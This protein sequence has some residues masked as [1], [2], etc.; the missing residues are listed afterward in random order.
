MQVRLERAYQGKE[1]YRG[2][3]KKPTVLMTSSRCI[4]EQINRRCD[5]SHDHVHLVGGGAAAAQVYPDA[6]CQSIL[7]G[8]AERQKIDASRQV[9]S[10]KMS[11]DH[12]R[13][14]IGS[15]FCT[16][17]GTVKDLAKLTKPIGNWPDN[18]AEPAHQEDGGLDQYGSRPRTA[19]Q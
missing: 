1:G 14:F 5:G 8:I 16:D 12:L 17:V 7:R 4:A 13:S 11:Q 6:L 18:W 19:F 9:S 2:W 10:P 3:V 15:V